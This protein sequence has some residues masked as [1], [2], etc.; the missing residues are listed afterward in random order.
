MRVNLL[1]LDAQST[2]H[3]NDFEATH[4][5]KEQNVDVLHPA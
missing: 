4:E 2:K 3:E 1:V 5:Q